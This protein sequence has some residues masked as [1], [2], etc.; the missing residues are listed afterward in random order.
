MFD[1]INEIEKIMNDMIEL[2]RYFHKYPEVSLKEE[3]TADKI[4]LE[5]KKMGI[6]SRRTA[7]TGVAAYIGEGSKTI[8]LRADMDA[9]LVMEKTNAPYASVNEG[10]MHACGHDGHMAALLGAAGILK[11]H[12][13]ELSCRVKVIFQPSEENCQGAKMICD[14]GEIEEL[15][16]IFGLHLF[17]DLPWGKISIEPGPRMAISDLFTIR[18][19]GRQG[20][21]GKPHQCLDATVAG[22]SLIMDLQTIV[23][24]ELDPLSSAVVT[25][26]YFQSGTQANIISGE[27]VIK[28]TVRTFTAQDQERIENAIY[29]MAKGCARLYNMKVSVE[30][31]S[32]LHPEVYNNE[33]KTKLALRGAR[34]IFPEDTFI[35]VPK[36]FLGED[37]SIYQKKIPGVFAFVGAGNEEKGFI[38]PNHHNCFDID[39][40]ALKYC[41]GL[42]VAYILENGL[43]Q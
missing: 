41:A 34:R 12:E 20:H 28:G 19:M 21:A 15:D 42:Y 31:G 6:L 32:K 1:V 17:T 39:E 40:R 43:V 29:R 8:G 24:R 13:K 5:L 11:A 35:E 7:G 23:S 30:Y 26:G 10:I 25:I 38:Y 33:D 36:I 9:L 37:F 4:Q 27:S 18:L 3:K 14:A 2:R 22:A 16:S